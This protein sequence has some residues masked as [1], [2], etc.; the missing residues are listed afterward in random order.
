MSPTE[1]VILPRQTKQS[2]G[3]VRPAVDLLHVAADKRES[4]RREIVDRRRATELAEK[5]WLDPVLFAGSDDS[6][7]GTA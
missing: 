6:H 7:A 1:G 5:P 4:V 2:A 3:A